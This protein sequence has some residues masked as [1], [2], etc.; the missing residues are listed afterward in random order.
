MQPFP[1][2]YEVTATAVP[3]GDVHLGTGDVPPLAAPVH[4]EARVAVLLPCCAQVQF[5]QHEG[6]GRRA[7]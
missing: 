1:Q 4:L 7:G 2:H 5:P 3:D 6:E